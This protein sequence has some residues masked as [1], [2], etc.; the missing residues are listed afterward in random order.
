MTP[1]LLR[2]DVGM[3]FWPAGKSA[4]LLADEAG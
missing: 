3:I 1:V 2:S 4:T